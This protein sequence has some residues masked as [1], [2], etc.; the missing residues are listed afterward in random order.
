METTNPTNQE[1][2][3]R[4]SCFL[5]EKQPNIGLKECQNLV[6]ELM[7]FKNHWTLSQFLLNLRQ[8]AKVTFE[9]LEPE[10]LRL[11]KFEPL[12]QI[13]GVADFLGEEFIVTKDTLIPRP[14]T[15]EL[16]LK[17][18]SFLEQ[19]PVGN[20]LEIGV[21]TGCIILSLER[22]VGRHHY[23]GCD[24]SEEALIVAQKNRDKFNLQTEL[25]YSDVFSNVP[26]EKFECII[27]NPPY[28][29]FSEETLM[30]ESVRRYEPTQ[31]LF[32]ENEGLAIYE[33][34]ANRLEEFLTDSGQ[35]FFEIGFNQ[36]PS[37]QR[38][39]SS[40]CPNRKITIHKDIAG[41][42]RMII[43]SGKEAQ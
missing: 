40:A 26:P 42:D 18:Q 35:A 37:V 20:V 17:V 32:A 21:G 1:V 2:L 27:S 31:A 28:I 25:F 22:L 3:I 23:M 43:V 15:E 5:E 6:R 38:I 11:S 14:E 33:K 9:D 12:Q 10:L 7:L 16:V 19:C 24:I 39:F 13:T 41:M 36:G 8:E 4:A 30:D 29:A 34:I